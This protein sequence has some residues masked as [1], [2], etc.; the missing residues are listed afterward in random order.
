VQTLAVTDKWETLVGGNGEGGIGIGC[1]CVFRRT[2]Q[3]ETGLGEVEKDVDRKARVIEEVGAYTGWN[4][5]ISPEA[6]AL[7]LR[8]WRKPGRGFWRENH[9]ARKGE[10][11]GVAWQFKDG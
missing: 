4:W 8:D 10:S 3:A 1:S 7:R 11:S 6:M 9:R 5:A 2:L